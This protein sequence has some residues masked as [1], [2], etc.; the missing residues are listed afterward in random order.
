MYV[1]LF[2]N[3]NYFTLIYLQILVTVTCNLYIFYRFH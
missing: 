3:L 1:L 2:L